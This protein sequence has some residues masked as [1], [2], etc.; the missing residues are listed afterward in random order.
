[1]TSR[2]QLRTRIASQDVL[3]LIAEHWAGQFERF[4]GNPRERSREDVSCMPSPGER[5]L[6]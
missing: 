2:I 4:P 3:V 1:M 5:D 6:E